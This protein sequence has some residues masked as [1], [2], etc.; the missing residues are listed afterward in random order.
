[1]T[2]LCKK[3]HAASRMSG[4]NSTLCAECQPIL[5]I[6]MATM[7]SITTLQLQ[8]CP[9]ENKVTSTR[10]RAQIKSTSKIGCRGSKARPSILELLPT[11]TNR[12][13]V[14]KSGTSR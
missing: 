2:S 1:M 13:L 7:P 9:R 5:L 10:A 12:H 8:I 6:I 3:S 4:R 11:L 14:V